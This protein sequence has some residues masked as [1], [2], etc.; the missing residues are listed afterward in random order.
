MATTFNFKRVY[1][2]ELPVRL[3]HWVTVFSMLVLT[4]T[5]FI[6]ADP[7]AINTNVEATNSH[8][9]GYVRAIHFITAY[10]LIANS[11]F[12]LYWAFAGNQFANWRNFIPYTKKGLKNIFHVLKVDIF[13]MEDKEHKLHNI[14]IGHN[15]LAAF[16][17]FIMALFFIVQVVTGLALIA[18]TSDWWFPNMFKW[19]SN[20]LGGDILT[21]YI[22]HILTWVFM[23]FAI[24]HVYLVLFH[25]YVEA[26]GE[27]S[28]MFSGF[29]FIRSERVK[30]TES[31]I[32]KRA[33]EQMREGKTIETDIEETKE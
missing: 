7:P 5:G 6:I 21:R 33:T 20:M 28:S 26:R 31:E 15:Y 14:S 18:D 1:V 24:I 22:H 27:A 29:K 12:R 17:Y 13:L 32:I 2:W 19:V 4:I 23:A 11:I 8:W 30:E 3:F 9:F 10:L 25:D 16:S